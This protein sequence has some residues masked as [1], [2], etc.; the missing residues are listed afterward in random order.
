MICT[1]LSTGKRKTIPLIVTISDIN[2]NTPKFTNLPY[3]VPVPEVSPQFLKITE[4]VS[5][6]KKKVCSQTVLPE[7][8]KIGGKWKNEKFWVIFKQCENH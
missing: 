6:Y 1:V 4:K 2:D 8:S 7:K 3:V 5:F